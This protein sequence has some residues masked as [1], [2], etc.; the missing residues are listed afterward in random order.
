MSVGIYYGYAKFIK[1]ANKENK[2]DYLD[3]D[4]I[5]KMVM[6][7]GFNPYYENK[8]KTAV[9]LILFYL[10]TNYFINVGGTFNE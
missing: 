4:K 2:K 3:Y 5:Y 7:I 1:P 8:F 10:K 9:I 6:S